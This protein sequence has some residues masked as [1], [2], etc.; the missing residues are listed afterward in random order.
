MQKSIPSDPVA[1]W[2]ERPFLRTREV[3]E[4]LAVSRSTVYNL[5]KAG[6]LRFISIGQRTLVDTVSLVRYVDGLKASAAVQE[7]RA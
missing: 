2:S 6:K 4:L 5:E 7:A 3:A 1:H